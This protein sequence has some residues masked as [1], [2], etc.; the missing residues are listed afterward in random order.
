MY[1]MLAIQSKESAELSDSPLYPCFLRSGDHEE[2]CVSRQAQ[3]KSLP[4][5]I[6]TNT[7]CG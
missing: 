7:G 6:S 3:A 4:K 1:M 5:S 2:D